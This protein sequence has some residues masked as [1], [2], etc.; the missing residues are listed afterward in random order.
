MSK[1]IDVDAPEEAISKPK[2]EKDGVE[3]WVSTSFAEHT[4]IIPVSGEPKAVAFENYKLAVDT[5]TTEGKK[6]AQGL[7]DSGREG[8]DIFRV[9]EAY[10]TDIKDMAAMLKQLR[11]MTPRQLR[12]LVTI[13]DL[14]NAGLPA[15]TD[16]PGDLIA[17]IM[18]KKRFIAPEK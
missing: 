7:R 18:A 17:V 14:I 11:D 1:K 6:I 9:G 5:K 16:D 2:S 13:E 3:E 4:I 8:R 10:D 12:A 15:N